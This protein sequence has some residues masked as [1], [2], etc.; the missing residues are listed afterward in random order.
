MIQTPLS[1]QQVYKTAV[2]TTALLLLPYLSWAQLNSNE[3]IAEIQDQVGLTWGEG[4]V[5]TFKSGDHR[6]FQRHENV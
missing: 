5:D 6:K 4:T 3:I 2:L 1:I